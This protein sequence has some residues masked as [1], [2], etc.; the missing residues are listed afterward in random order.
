MNFETKAFKFYQS[1]DISFSVNG[2]WRE[3]EFSQCSSVCGP[4]FKTKKKVCDSPLPSGGELCPCN[5]SVNETICTGL[6]AII[7]EQCNPGTCEGNTDLSN[8]MS[9]IPAKKDNQDMF[10]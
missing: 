5:Q 2:N 9:F 1:L 6:Y 8:M 10:F 3:E 7:E 4:G